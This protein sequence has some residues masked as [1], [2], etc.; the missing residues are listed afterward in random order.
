[1]I[2]NISEALPIKERAENYDLPLPVDPVYLSTIRY[3][4]TDGELCRHAS[5]PT[6]VSLGN[7]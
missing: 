6:K 3:I 2:M 4:Y 5:H 1:M 7:G